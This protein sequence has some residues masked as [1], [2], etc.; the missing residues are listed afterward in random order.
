MA[1]RG[2]P[3]AVRRKARTSTSGQTANFNSLS[4]R[5]SVSN[6]VNFIKMKVY[7]SRMIVYGL[8]ILFGL[9]LV[10]FSQIPKVHRHL[11]RMD[12]MLKE[13]AP[14]FSMA[15]ISLKK[16]EKKGNIAINKTR[17][18]EAFT[19][20][21][22]RIFIKERK[23]G[24]IFELKGL[25]FEWRDFSDLVWSDN[26]TLMFDRW[27]EPHYGN[28]YAVNAVKK[29]LLDAVPFPDAFMLKVKSRIKSKKR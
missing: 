6:G 17:T 14:G 5:S 1:G 22:T 23:T 4:V 11:G 7:Q 29:K 13:V 26:Q 25:P 16:D 18:L 12:S 3:K 2:I 28:H 21:D 24:K 20:D 19:V 27:V 15:E 10:V 9:P 8:A